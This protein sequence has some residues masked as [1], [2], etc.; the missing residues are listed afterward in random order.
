MPPVTTLTRVRTFSTV[1]NLSGWLKTKS[2]VIILTSLSGSSRIIT[3]VLPKP[4][5][6][7]TSSEITRNITSGIMVKMD[8]RSLVSLL[9]ALLIRILQFIGRSVRNLVTRGISVVIVVLGALL[10][11]ILVSIASAG[12]WLCC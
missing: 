2:V 1:I 9:I 11:I 4:P 12:S 8:V 7:I 10:P 5:S 3:V 6:R